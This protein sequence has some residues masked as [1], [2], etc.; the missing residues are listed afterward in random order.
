[1]Q[2]R[3]R[4]PGFIGAAVRTSLLIFL[5]LA[6]AWLAAPELND[7]TTS[8]PSLLLL[9]PGLIAT[10][11]A[12]P[13]HPLVTRLLNLA[14]WTLA[15]SGGLAYIAAGRLA[16][17]T[18]RHRTTTHALRLWLGPSALVAAVLCAVLFASWRLPRRLNAR[19]RMPSRGDA[20]A[21]IR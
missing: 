17:V 4:G 2:F 13:A 19:E 20:A 10:Y 15:V 21:Q 1:M 3:V 11:L 7:T 9:F 8:A 12:R 6:A 16:F 14:R 18:T 5:A